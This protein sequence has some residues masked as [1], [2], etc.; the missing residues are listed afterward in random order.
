[1]DETALCRAVATCSCRHPSSYQTSVASRTSS[2]SAPESNAS[3]ASYTSGLNGYTQRP[4]VTRQQAFTY[5]A[6]CHVIRIVPGRYYSLSNPASQSYPSC[7][8]QRSKHAA[9]PVPPRPPCDAVRNS[10][11]PHS[12]CGPP[13]RCGEHAARVGGGGSVHGQA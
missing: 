6:M 11:S 1:M 7:S 9:T 12:A 3:T 10:T 5:A 4:S 13:A 2:S 8:S